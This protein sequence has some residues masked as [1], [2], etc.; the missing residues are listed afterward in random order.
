MDQLQ[1]ELHI[2]FPDLEISILGVNDLASEPGN[3]LIT[4]D[5]DL[6]WLQDIDADGDLHSDVWALWDV[7]ERDVI[8]VDGNN[9]IAGRYNLTANDL[10]EPENY[11]DLLNLFVNVA[12]LEKVQ[13]RPSSLS[14]HVYFDVNND[15]S[16]DPVELA[17][18]NVKVTLTGT[19]NQGRDISLVQHTEA[20]GTYA[21][22]G[23]SAGTY[24]ITQSQPAFLIDG[25]E[26]LGSAGGRV[27]HNQ[28]TVELEEGLDGDGYDF[29][30]RGRQASAIGVVD[31]FASTSHDAMLSCADPGTDSD[32][33]ALMGDWTKYQFAQVDLAANGRDATV[34]ARDIHGH[35]F[36]GGFTT[37]HRDMHVLAE[38]ESQTLVRFQGELTDLTALLNAADPPQEVEG[39]DKLLSESPTTLSDS[40]ITLAAPVELAE[41]ELLLL[42]A[43]QPPVA[44]R[45]SLPAGGL[46]PEGTGEELAADELMADSVWLDSLLLPW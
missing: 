9:V 38:T 32:W 39:E 1:T 23:L 21:F 30:E 31:L 36:E 19:T 6:P 13:T 34:V 41:G 3:E 20:D 5:R 8:I 46:R 24:T 12:S 15:A 25:Q 27:G 11:A 42:Y 33:Y 10:A 28:F 22:L 17:I 16:M 37:M 43:N 4:N 14:G 7:T 40:P 26:S 18:G 44:R 29:G 2:D 45:S 35:D